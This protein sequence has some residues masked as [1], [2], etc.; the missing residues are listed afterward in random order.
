M[1]HAFNTDVF[2]DVRP[3]DALA[4][5]NETEVHALLWRGF[6]QSPRPSEGHANH[7]AVRELGDDLV[8]GNSHVLNSR[9]ASRSAHA[10][11]PGSS[12]DLP[13]QAFESRAAPEH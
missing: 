9:I 13:R 8:L 6:R 5:S 2:I 1:K 3:M 7:S 4:G 10:M 12:V 11:P